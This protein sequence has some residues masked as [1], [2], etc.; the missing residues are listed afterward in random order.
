MGVVSST[1]SASKAQ[2]LGA[3][4]FLQAF[5]SGHTDN[6]EP[7]TGPVSR[8]HNAAAVITVVVIGIVAMIGI[9]IFGEIWNALPM[10][11]GDPLYSEAEAIVGGFG[12]AMGLVPIILLVLLASIVIGV[13]QRMRG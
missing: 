13:V 6:L 8:A 7:A 3:L 11:S 9:L 4:A 2:L 5:V 1:L 10:Q 12:D